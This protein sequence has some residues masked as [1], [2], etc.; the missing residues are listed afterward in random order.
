MLKWRVGERPIVHA[1][2]RS[3]GVSPRGVVARLALYS[4]GGLGAK[5][6][7]GVRFDPKR[8]L[9]RLAPYIGHVRLGTIARRR[10]RRQ[11]TSR[12][13]G[14]VRSVW[15]GGSRVFMNGP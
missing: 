10:R 11:P 12:V 7:A 8:T 4:M 13:T 15:G 9:I 14:G 2:V 3:I 1:T 6:P 5:V